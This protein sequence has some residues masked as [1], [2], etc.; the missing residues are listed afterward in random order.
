MRWRDREESENVEDRRDE[1]SRGGGFPGGFPMPGG[2]GGGLGIVGLLVVLGLSYFL[3]ID[4]RIIL[5]DGNGDGVTFPQIEGPGQASQ[6]PSEE[7]KELTKFTSVVLK[8]TED[9]WT[10]EFRRL[11]KTYTAPKL[12]LFRGGVDSRCGTGVSQMGPFYCP[13][14]NK[15]YLDLSFYSDLKTRFRA[16]GEFAEAYVIAHEI[17]H[18]VQTQLGIMDKV[19]AARARGSE[20]QSNAI[21]VRTELQ[22]DCFAGLWANRA[23][24][25]LQIV[26]PGDI[27]AALNAAAAIG[28][29]RLQKRTQG[30]VVPDAFTHGTSEQ[31]VTWFRKGFDTGKLEACDTFGQGQI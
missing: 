21:Q 11:G 10:E 18:H 4:P 26:E 3:G 12:V 1:P 5:G 19:M 6:P 23:Q 28:D 22:A 27:E 9:I 14:D 15:V 2:R 25:T 31:R 24:Q 30:R 13:L 20:T 7:D 16:P 8:T 17:G 29:D